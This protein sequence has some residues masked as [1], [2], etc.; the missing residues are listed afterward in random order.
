MG[1][2]YGKMTAILWK[3]CQEPQSKIEHLEN[4][5]F[6]MMEDIKRLKGK[7]KGEKPKA[8]SKSKNVD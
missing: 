3:C 7:G 4:R 8:K 1:I 2:K 5:L 6:E